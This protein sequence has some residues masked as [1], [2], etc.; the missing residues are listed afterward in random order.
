MSCFYP[1]HCHF[2]F[3]FIWLHWWQ[4]SHFY[5]FSITVCMFLFVHHTFS[6]HTLCL[7]SFLSPSVFSLFCFSSW[8]LILR[9]G[10]EILCWSVGSSGMKYMKWNIFINTH[11]HTQRDIPVR[12]HF[13]AHDFPFIRIL[14]KSL[15][16]QRFILLSLQ[17]YPL[18]HKP[19]TVMGYVYKNE[20]TVFPSFTVNP[21]LFCA[22][23]WF[24]FNLTSF[25]F[26]MC[27]TNVF[28]FF[29]HFFSN[30]SFTLPIALPLPVPFPLT[31]CWQSY[32]TAA[33]LRLHPWKQIV[34]NLLL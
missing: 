7:F 31:S 14:W 8:S 33:A 27:Q 23:H 26:K 12:C 18:T 5:V 9:G 19:L 13:Q 10:F 4:Y 20:H 11:S 1:F 22:Q 30:Y 29:F 32:N 15:S 16:G 28:F 6:M 34:W 17:M 25:N 21:N 2:I 3:H 24:T